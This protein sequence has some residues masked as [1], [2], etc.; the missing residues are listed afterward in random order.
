MRRLCMPLALAGLLLSTGLP[1]WAQTDADALLR[2]A[3]QER[4][5]A[6]L[7][8]G[9]LQ[10]RLKGAVAGPVDQID[11]LNV[12]P[13][14]RRFAAILS[15]DG[16]RQRVEGEIWTEIQV[17]VPNRRLAPG[18]VISPDDL[19]TIPMRTDQVSQRTITDARGLVG[20]E[21]RRGLAAGRPI[22]GNAITSQPVVERNKPVTLQYR[23]GALL[24][25]ARGRAL[26]DGAVGDTVRVQNLDSNRSLTA[27]VIGPGTVSAAD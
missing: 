24:I 4:Y 6:A 3:I 26:A 1:A 13:N 9:E 17:P 20:M 16:Q 15:R 21:V 2:A 5:G 25:T 27:T 10:L 23:Q 19:T 7:G 11:A 12:D 14:T 8:D 22:Q 18:E